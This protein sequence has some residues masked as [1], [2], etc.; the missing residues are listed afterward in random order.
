MP[1]RLPGEAT[2]SESDPEPEAPLGPLEPRRCRVH[3][4]GFS[5]AAAGQPVKLTLTARDAN[6]KRIREGGAHVLVM[7]EPQAPPPAPAPGAAPLPDDADAEPIQAEISDHGDGTYT[8][9]YTAPYKGLYQVCAGWRRRREPGG[10]CMQPAWLADALV[11]SRVLTPAPVHPPAPHTNDSCTLKWTASRWATRP[12][13]STSLH[14]SRPSQATQAPAPRP[15]TPA[16]AAR[17]CR[18]PC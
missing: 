8:A 10:R 13:Q 12:I 9:L 5:G 18:R 1:K 4:P 15:P 7:V 6:G 14:P 11:C 3:G 16:P 17:D 2:D